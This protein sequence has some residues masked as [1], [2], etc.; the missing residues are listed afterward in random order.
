MRNK[1]RQYFIKLKSGCI[2]RFLLSDLSIYAFIFQIR[3]K[4]EDEFQICVPPYQLCR[5]KMS[6]TIQGHVA[7]W[8]RR[9]IGT[10]IFE[11]ACSGVATKLMTARA[12]ENRFQR[13][14]GRV[15]RYQ[16]SIHIPSLFFSLSHTHT[17]CD[18]VKCREERF[19]SVSKR[20]KAL[21]ERRIA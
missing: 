2:N 12:F 7:I 16:L 5:V 18:V 1:L 20:S 19:S 6:R 17:L 11:N 8:Q 10:G 13:Y 4:M 9:V 14:A 21:S 3:V 15:L